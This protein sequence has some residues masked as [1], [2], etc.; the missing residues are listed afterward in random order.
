M[1]VAYRGEEAV[2][3]G[4]VAHHDGWSEVKRLWVAPE[5]RGLGVARRLLAALEADAVRR[6]SSAVRL[7]TS[8]HLTEAMA[9]YRS[10]GYTEIARFNDEVF[11]DFW[12]E[13]RLD[14][15]APE[16]RTG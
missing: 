11:A 14:L 1:L 12:F 15:E 13:K 4:G 3:C 7:D 9:L 5:I 6:G 10:T 2:G 16:P 8:R